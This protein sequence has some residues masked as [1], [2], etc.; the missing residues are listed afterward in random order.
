MTIFVKMLSISFFVLLL[1]CAGCE[2]GQVIEEG[3]IR[4]D[5]DFSK[6]VFYSGFAPMKIDIMPLTNFFYDYGQEQTVLNVYLNLKDQFDSQVKAPGTFRFELYKFLPRSSQ[7][8]GKRVIIWPDIDL[9][10]AIENNS[11]WRDFLRA[12]Q[13]NLPFEP[14][15]NQRYILLVTYM[16]PNGKRLSVEFYIKGAK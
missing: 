8:K 6:P 16:Y 15:S 12:Y 5:A 3:S 2:Q 11:Y 13:F 1:V 10:G 9:T 7:P 14:A 4:T